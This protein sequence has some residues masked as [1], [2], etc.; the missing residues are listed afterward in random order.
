MKRI[1]F[2]LCFLG[3]MQPSLA[4]GLLFH[5]SLRNSV[6]CYDSDEVHT[7]IYQYVRL[8]LSDANQVLSFQASGRALTDAQ[9]ELPDDQR[10]KA[11]TMNLALRNPFN[12]KL[13]L[14]LGRQFLH[15]GTILGGLDGLDAQ[16]RFTKS[17]SVQLYGGTQSSLLRQFKVNE[18][19]R[20]IAGG[21]AQLA[22]VYG[23]TIQGL[24][25]QKSDQK[26]LLWQVSGVNL[27]SR[28]IPHTALTMQVHFDL[29]NSSLHRLLLSTRHPVS[30][31]LTLNFGFKHQ[32]P[33]VYASSFFTIFELEGYNQMRAGASYELWPDYYLGCDYQ[34]LL[35]EESIANKVYLHFSNDNGSL[36]MIYE[37]GYSGDQIGVMFDYAYE[38]IQDLIASVYVDYTKYR[39]EEIYE[40]DNQLG[41]AARLSYHL[42]KK[43]SIDVEY[44]WLSNPYKKQDSRLLNHLSFRW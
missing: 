1:L 5:G 38:L 39:T 18:P 22:N 4:Q 34:L 42:T 2:I 36:G 29:T 11:Y 8:S 40:Y 28:L 21:L 35:I 12:K 13:N 31:Q 43:L 3:G 37:N 9:V 20:F 32:A 15:P 41:N 19:E 33:Q 14:V 16:M 17:F 23:S 30:D 6:Y 44:Q 7:R 27:Y 10:F 25:L 24:Y 26:G